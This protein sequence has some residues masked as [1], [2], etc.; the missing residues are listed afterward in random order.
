MTDNINLWYTGPTK[1]LGV[2]LMVG[3]YFSGTGNTRFCTETFLDSYD[4]GAESCS[5]ESPDAL[6]LLR[7]HQEIL[8]AYPIYYSS[9]PKI[10][11]DFLRAHGALFAGKTVF[12]LS[13]MGL[14]SGDGAGCAA[15]VLRGYGAH[16][17]G[18]LH[19]RMPDS[20]SDEKALKKPL[21][22]NRALVQAAK[23]KVCAAA[24]QL[25]EGT[26]PRDGLGFLPHAAG[27]LGQRLWFGHKVKR[28][29]DRLKI[30]PTTCVGCGRCAE[31]CPMGNL[32]IRDGKAVA[33]TRCT[34][35]YRCVNHCPAQAITLLGHQ[36][37]GQSTIEA[38]L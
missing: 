32:T 37:W 30:D 6:R 3:I 38:Y 22:S 25:R 36:V 20:I 12:L 11:Q 18:G 34:M 16:I 4:T 15:R 1:I 21:E 33:G 24:H 27:L 35:C 10:V 31:G 26:P 23:E 28:Y 19:V 8:F 9:L 5:I 2:W 13:T 14:F 7:E 17:A 29:S